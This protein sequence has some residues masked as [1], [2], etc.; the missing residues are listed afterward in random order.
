MIRA[1]IYTSSQEPTELLKKALVPEPFIHHLGG[2]GNRRV[3]SRGLWV[4]GLGVEGFGVGVVWGLRVVGGFR[5]RG[6]WGFVRPGF[7]V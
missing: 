1:V 4:E 7:R 5:G 3:G 2:F 6:L